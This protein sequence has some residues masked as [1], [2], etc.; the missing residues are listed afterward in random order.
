M[1]GIFTFTYET[2]TPESAEY[3]DAEERGF[4]DPGH[5]KYQ[6][7]NYDGPNIWRPGDLSHYIRFAQELNITKDGYS[8]DPDRDY[9][10]GSEIHYAMHVEG[11][12]PSTR[13]RIYRLLAD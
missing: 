11:C 10:N 3:G 8:V 5:W 9:N 2:I 7:E 6:P 13:Q 4:I 1:W 12:T